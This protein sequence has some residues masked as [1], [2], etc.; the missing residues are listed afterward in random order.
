MPMSAVTP[1]P[2]G[3]T[4]LREHRHIC[5]FFNSVKEE[6]DTLGPFIS[7][8]IHRGDRTVLVYPAKNKDDHVRRLKAAGLDVERLEESGQLV[9]EVPENTYLRTGKFNKDDMLARIQEGLA[10]SRARGYS[11]TRMIA[12]TEAKISGWQNELEL[13]EYEVLLNKALS[14]SQ[15]PVICIYDIN[16][17]SAALMMDVLRS[18]P[19]AI[20]GG[21]L[22]HN[23]YYTKV[24]KF[25]PE[26]HARQQQGYDAYRV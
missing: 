22:H 9:L 2:F 3:R 16:Q 13:I 8:G 20:I 1:I 10:D 12:H 25:L 21:V 6:Y 26:I 7:D 23:P 4:Y 17:M 18:H 19:M 24:S 5:A 11:V 14:H 15:D